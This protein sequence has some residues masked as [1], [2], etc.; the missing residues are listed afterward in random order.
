MAKGEEKTSGCLQQRVPEPGWSW[1]HSQGKKTPGP[2]T[3]L[4]HQLRASGQ[5][6]LV[7][8]LSGAYETEIKAQ[9]A[10]VTKDL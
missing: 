9:P 1:D 10:P 8:V 4:S 6:L 5:R 2:A 3:G 7:S